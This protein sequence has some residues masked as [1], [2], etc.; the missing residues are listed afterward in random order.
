M[1]YIVGFSRWF[2]GI[3]FIISGLIKLN[4]P[5][6]FSYKLEEYFSAD[7]LNIPFL[8]PYALAISLFVVIF[9][10]VLGVFLLIGFKRKFT[11]WSLLGMIVF[12]TFLTFYSAYFDK[13]KDC[14]C[15][16]DA[17][18]LTPWESFWK[19]VILLVFILILFK[20]V[21][22]IRPI[23]KEKINFGLAILS[24]LVCVW[25]GYHV[26]NHLPSKDFRAYKIG[27]NIPEGMVIP[28]DAPKPVIDY[29]W[30][31]NVN[32]EEQIVTTRGSY[33]T[34]EGGD[35]VSVETE[36]VEE[37]Y[38]PP[39]FD[40]SI[41][42]ADEDLTEAFLAEENLV[43]VIA[44]SLEKMNPEGAKAMKLLTDKAIKNGYKVIGMSASGETAKQSVKAAYGFNFEFYLCDEK[45]L[46]TVVRSNPGVLELDKGTVKQ[47]LHWKDV[48]DF[49]VSALP[50]A[51]PNLNLELKRQL[52]SIM[53]LDQKYRQDYNADTWKLQE[54]IDSTN[55]AFIETIFKTHGYP[56]KSLVGEETQDVAWYVIQH[57]HKIPVYLPLM[58]TAAQKGEL[59]MDKVAMMEDRYLMG[60]G[61]LQIYGTQGSSYA[62]G[63]PQEVNFIWPIA[64]PETVN[65]RRKEVGLD[66]TIEAYSKR[67]FGEDFKYKALTL[68]EKDKLLAPFNN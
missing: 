62:I 43:V 60:K 21:K 19:D 33:P 12:F 63:T 13:V 30:K 10:V 45:A 61:E 28:E 44:Y 1:K 59:P 17:L 15:F 40:F 26:L 37:G 2:V 3:L 65:E 50:N 57:S 51:N 54:A 7:V 9:E 31:F 42:S 38:E 22:H 58:K 46:K 20:G 67:L 14:G 55:T 41:E 56:G 68:E 49:N 47:K 4:D 34:V 32:G 18:K 6:G 36:T 5:L 25:F 52:D 66:E 16:G 48:D 8:E 29:H 23:F 35:Y 64:N 53:V 27:A 11:V 39:I 24:V